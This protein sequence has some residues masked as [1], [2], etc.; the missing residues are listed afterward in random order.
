[1]TKRLT[2]LGF[3]AV[4]VV[5]GPYV[6]A[7]LAREPLPPVTVEP[8]NAVVDPTPAAYHAPAPDRAQLLAALEA[9]QE[10][11][12]Q[13]PSQA[14]AVAEPIAPEPALG[15]PAPQAPEPVAAVAPPAAANTDT[16]LAPATDPTVA[17]AAPGQ[18]PDH[19]AAQAAN[20][21]APQPAAAPA[22]P[23]APNAA[24]PEAEDPAHAAAAKEQAE[25]ASA[26]AKHADE[27]RAEDA[28]RAD[29]KEGDEATNPENLAPAFRSAFD[30]ESRDAAWA[31]GEEPRLAQILAGAGV[32]ASAIGEV[33]CQSTVCRVAL[34][35][36]DMKAAQQ[37]PL[38]QLLYQR[39]RDEFGTLGVDP[40]GGDG[41]QHAAL[42][43]LRKGYEL[44]RA[45]DTN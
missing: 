20:G 35:S 6:Y 24:K 17:A 38:Y 13:A 32:P 39:V 33:R 37:S 11:A 25:A 43:V 9:D 31:S 22:D 7:E 5:W 30:R 28:K 44:E 16:T 15:E 19:P 34:T 4:A 26:E 23:D 27:K 8:S 3:A 40:A 36:V 18:P 21:L 42:Y 41:E 1:M 12:A 29:K 45:R 2:A 10:K 14:N